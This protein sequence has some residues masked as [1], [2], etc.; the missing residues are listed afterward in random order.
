VRLYDVVL[1]DVEAELGYPPYAL[2][3]DI[4]RGG[5]QSAIQLEILWLYRVWELPE[6][7]QCTLQTTYPPPCGQRCSVKD[8]A[9]EDNMHSEIGCIREL[10]LS[11]HVDR[12]DAALVVHP[13][14]CV[15]YS[16]PLLLMHVIRHTGHA[17]E[18]FDYC[19]FVTILCSVLTL[20]FFS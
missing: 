4:W 11:D 17:L 14:R 19:H 10:W 20:V 18:S 8:N 16:Q 1:M 12:K 2:V 13:V 3:T 9:T 5:P 6:D 15:S 7:L